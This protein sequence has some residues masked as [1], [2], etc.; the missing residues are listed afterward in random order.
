MRKSPNRSFRHP[1]ADRT[2]TPIRAATVS[3]Y[4]VGFVPKLAESRNAL[5]APSRAP[6]PVSS[7]L[8][9]FSL[10]KLTQ[11]LSKTIGLAQTASSPRSLVFSALKAQAESAAT[12]I[13][14]CLDPSAQRC[15]LRADLRGSVSPRQIHLLEFPLPFRHGPW[16]RTLRF[17]C[18]LCVSAL[19]AKPVW[20]RLCR[21]RERTRRDNSWEHLHGLPPVASLF[22]MR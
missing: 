5:R 22:F 12:N 16:H 8:F 11:V 19:K 2:R 3:T 4:V 18:A 10:R 9:L 1:H 21:L 7:I 14:Q 6:R 13:I 17:L 15:F 20:F